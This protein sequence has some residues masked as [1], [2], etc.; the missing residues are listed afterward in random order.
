MAAAEVV[1]HR[2]VTYVE[3]HLVCGT[4][5]LDIVGVIRI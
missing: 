3:E 1:D 4:L 5:C 2:F